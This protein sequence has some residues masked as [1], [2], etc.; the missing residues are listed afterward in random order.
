M[1]YLIPLVFLLSGCI[2]SDDKYIVLKTDYG[3]ENAE[4]VSCIDGWA[5]WV[6]QDN[7]PIV[8]VYGK[9]VRCSPEVY[10]FDSVQLAWTQYPPLSLFREK[11]IGLDY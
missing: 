9:H 3:I 4:Y 6:R 11:P 8:T 10:S 5:Y 2:D 1:K 7:S